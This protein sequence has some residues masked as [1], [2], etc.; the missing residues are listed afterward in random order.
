MDADLIFD[1]VKLAF[2]VFSVGIS[3]GMK[4]KK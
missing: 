1:L 3:I 2:V 4:I